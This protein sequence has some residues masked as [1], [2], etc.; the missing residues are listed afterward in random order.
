MNA[1]AV[2]YGCC[3]CG[4]GEKTSIAAQTNRARGWVNGEPLRF[5]IGHHRRK[6]SVRYLIEDRGYVTACWLWQGSCD[7]S[8]YAQ[9]R[10]KGKLAYVH[11][12][13]FERE[14][15]PIPEGL[16][17]DHLCRVVNC[18]RPS[19]LEPVTSGEN[20]RRGVG[21]ALNWSLVRQMR[22]EAATMPLNYETYR[23][24]APKYGVIPG[25]VRRVLKNDGWK[26]EAQ[27]KS[28]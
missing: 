6:S 13:N 18:V 10:T 8:G 22:G 12:E 23:A 7:R 25:T 1:E 11:R 19:H 16:V 28:A 21:L 27:C 15:G 20:R 24:L 4:C 3:E 2:E 14:C 26:E 5:R 17:L 9:K